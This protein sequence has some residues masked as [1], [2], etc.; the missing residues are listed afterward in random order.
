ME[1]I[2][3]TV[4][5]IDNESGVDIGNCR[6]VY[7]TNANSIGTNES[8]Y[9]NKFSNNG[10]TIDLTA[11]TEG[12][13]YL[14]V[15]TVDKAGRKTETI[16]QAVT[17]TIPNAAP[18]ISA[19]NFNSK[20]EN[21]ITI[22]A[23][24]TDADN[25][26]LTYTLYTS[27]SENGSYSEKAKQTANA[28]TKVS[29]QATGLNMYTSYYYYVTV[30]DGIVTTTSS[31]NT[32]KTYC[33]ASLCTGPFT[34]TVTC[35]TCNGTGGYYDGCT[36]TKGT[37]GSDLAG[38]AS[39]DYVCSFCGGHYGAGAAYYTG[40]WTCDRCGYTRYVSGK[41]CSHSHALGAA[42]ELGGSHSTYV[43]CPTTITQSINCSHGKSSQHYYC[44]THGNVNSEL[45]E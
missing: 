23:Q 22:D 15:L 34:Q 45:H 20:T 37:T 11:T 24:A 30:T 13:Y 42:Y 9:P 31:K 10:Q 8:S 28:N 41:V 6:W 5:H 4:T 19:V 40:W 18:V 43:S 1:T 25:N 39:S 7:N 16:S 35:P 14:H 36:S 32:V 12:T 26:N 17:V 21:S 33:K 29:L 3:A 27:T 38:Y 2:T 44:S